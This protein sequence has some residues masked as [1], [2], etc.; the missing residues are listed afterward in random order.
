MIDDA[1]QRVHNFLV[2]FGDAVFMGASFVL[3]AQLLDL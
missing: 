2:F 1:N 3:L